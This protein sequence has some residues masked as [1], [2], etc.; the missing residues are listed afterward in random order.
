MRAKAGKTAGA[1]AQPFEDLAHM[2][3]TRR[4]GAPSDIA[5]LAQTR[6]GY[7]W[8]G[9]SF[10]LFRF[11]GLKFQSYPFT[12]ADPRLPSAN[13]SALA[14]DRDGGLWIGFR[15]G[16]ISYL[17]GGR[18]TDYNGYRGVPSESTAQ[19]LC[20]DD[21]SVWAMADGRL[22]HFT[23]SGWE[24]YSAAHGV[25]SDGLYTLFFDRDDNLWTADKGHVF[26]L[27]KGAE[28]F[29][30]TPVSA[31]VVNQ[32][33][34]LP[35]GEMWISDAWRSV[36]PLAD[37]EAQNGVKIPGVPLM[38]TDRNGSVWLA[39]DFGGITRIR[40]PEDAAARQ[41]E[42]YTAGNGLTDGQTRAI[43]EDRQG[44]IW[45]G[46]ARGLD[47]F[48]PSPL[49]PFHGVQFDYYPALVAD[50]ND[51]IWLHDMDKPLM[52]LRGGQLQF[53][54]EGHGSSSLFQDSDGSVWLLDQIAGLLS[55][56]GGGSGAAIANSR[57]S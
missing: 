55:V 15:M 7:L 5:A 36:R 23:G 6:D 42:N 18:K 54:G 29:V 52:R 47:R 19:L 57:S 3:W 40:H 22:M 16:G 27:K 14:A 48:R 56:S 31:K 51:G 43:L 9:S 35:D 49:V 41:V 37:A 50:R 8:I 25:A 32:F 4:E 17:R 2:N 24:N 20:R 44:T 53:V 11:D 39:N 45:V 33:G 26:E 34:Q 46:T 21:G 30:Q 13:V 12:S 28:K 1:P 38:L 10:G